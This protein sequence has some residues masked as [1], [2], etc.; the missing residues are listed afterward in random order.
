MSLLYDHRKLVLHGSSGTGKSYMA[1]KLA[2]C[3]VRRYAIPLCALL[4]IQMRVLLNDRCLSFEI[5]K[6]ELMSYRNLFSSSSPIKYHRLFIM[7]LSQHSISIKFNS[8]PTDDW[9]SR[10]E[11]Q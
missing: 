5:N 4:S 8:V 1:M 10:I 3:I 2:Q 9:L 11:K 6:A 7:L